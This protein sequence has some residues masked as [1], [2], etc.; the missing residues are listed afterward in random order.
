METRPGADMEAVAEGSCE[1]P[2]LHDM[3]RMDLSIQA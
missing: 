2:R 1:G 3:P